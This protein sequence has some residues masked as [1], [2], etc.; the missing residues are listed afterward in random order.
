[1]SSRRVKSVLLAC[2]GL[3]AL[4]AATADANAGSFALRE[5]SAYGQGS[6]F[7]GIAAGGALSSMFWNP[8]TIT[9]FNGKTIEQDMTGILPNASHSY[10][11]AT[12]AA[13]GN[14]G[15]SAM[16]AL[17]PSG[18]AS[19]QLNDRFWLGMSV[20]APFGLG[21]HFPQ[22]WA[23]A[24]G[25]SGESAKIDSYNFA[26]TVAYKFNDLISIAVG[27]QAQ[28]LKAS[29]DFFLGASTIGALNGGGWSYG[30][31]AGVTL[32]PLP[33]TQIGIGYR[34]AI[35]QKINGNL[36]VPAT[37]PA[38]TR[39]SVNLV[40]PLPDVVTVGLRQGIGDRFT[41]LAGLEW[42]HWSRIG[43]P[44]VY[45]PSG[46]AA[47]VGGAPL[48][49]PF[50]YH[51]GWFYSLGG[52]Y[53]IDPAWT[54]RAGIAFEKSPITDDIRTARIPDNDRMWYS[55]GASYKPASLRGLT[56]D[57]GY[58]FINVKNTPL[59][60]GPA[61]AGGCPGNPWSS[62]AA[63]YV[64]S[65]DSHINIVSLAVRYQWDAD[66]APAPKSR[67]ITK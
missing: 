56:F 57:A 31:T 16:D 59:C 51:D 65:V 39:G 50:Q 33:K 6:S 24:R 40:L 7:A 43:T 61:A 66:P 60:L 15:N 29:Y 30:W 49:F 12:D 9:Q 23:G 37:I 13:L 55:V 8:A 2:C 17:V 21:V 27:V 11:I 46:A 62:A 38:T 28:Y 47:L 42:S 22:N 26:P 10:T 67:L 4:I 34:S 35:D 5:Q 45:Q 41:L 20:N 63:A 3:G 25:A 19:W 14:T 53:I 32:T 36:D 1:M 58:S 44:N 54:V 52:E 48:K 64:G 18:Y